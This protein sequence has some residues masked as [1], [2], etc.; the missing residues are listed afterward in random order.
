[1]TNFK[2][3]IAFISVASFS[4]FSQNNYWQQK[5]DYKIE[6]KLNDDKHEIYGFESFNYFN[7]SSDTLYFIYIHLWPNA[8]KND[9]TPLGKQLWEVKNQILRFGGDDKRGYI[10][11]LDFKVNEQKVKIEFEEVD[12][13][14]LILNTPL[15]PNQTLEVSTPFRVKIPSGEISRL[16]HIGQSYQITQWYPKP[17][18]YDK[19]GWNQISYLNQG[20]FY[21][22][23]GS[24]DVKIT[25]P[26]ICCRCYW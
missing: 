10:D 1:M 23:Y 8:Y 12:I 15:L 19:N 21:S 6:V 3:L 17:A 24:F 5:V 14:K 13:C 16:G 2:I 26:S 20:E 11:S 25:V 4:V 22:E 7:N 9:K 18:V